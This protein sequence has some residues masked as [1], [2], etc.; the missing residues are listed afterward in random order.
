M[1]PKKEPS[2]KTTERQCRRATIP[3]ASAPASVAYRIDISRFERWFIPTII[4]GTWRRIKSVGYH[5]VVLQRVICDVCG[6][7]VSSHAHFLVRIDVFADPSMPDVTTE[8][9]EEMDTGKAIDQLLEQMKHMSA[10]E[11]Q[12]GVH[13]RFEYKLCPACHKQFLS[14]PLGMPRQRRASEN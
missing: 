9:L 4:G 5:A 14:N 6:A 1:H 2:S 13:R 10:D 3:G 11:L 8:E 7:A 12:D